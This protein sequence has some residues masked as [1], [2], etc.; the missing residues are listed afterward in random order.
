MMCSVGEAVREL[1]LLHSPP[2][3]QFPYPEYNIQD[4]YLLSKV[5]QLSA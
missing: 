5:R 1:C 2:Q 4:S 3:K